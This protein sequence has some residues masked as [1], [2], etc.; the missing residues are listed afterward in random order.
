[1]RFVGEPVAVVIADDAYRAED[2]I[3]LVEVDWEPWPAVASI[4]AATAC[5]APQAAPE[6]AGNCLVD[7]LMFD[8]DRLQEIFATAAVTV[9]ATFRSARVAALPLEGRACLA[10]WDDRDDQL[11]LHVSTQ[12]PHQVRSGVAQALGLPERPGAGHRPGRRR[13][14]RPEVRRRPGR[15]R[16][17][18]GRAA[19]APAGALGRGPAGEPDRRVP[20][21]RAALP[22]AR[23]VRPGR[24]DPRPGR[25]DRLRH[26]S[27]LRVPVHLRGRAADGLDRTARHV[28]GA[29]LPGPRPGH[30]HQQGARRALPRAC[31]GRRSS[32]SWSG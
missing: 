28:Q 13:R 9:R 16:R 19:A 31:R 6:A 2:A 3:E 10:E 27:V 11:V 1:M 5:E 18:G 23:R 24:P 21:A 32:W 25:R 30:R 8:D 7:L 14:V 22:G 15:G 12:V 20:R 29:R 17:G 4:E 26:R